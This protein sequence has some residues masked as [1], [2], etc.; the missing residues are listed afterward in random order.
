MDTQLSL[1]IAKSNAGRLSR[2]KITNAF[3]NQVYPLDELMVLALDISNKNHYKAIWIVELLAEENIFFLNPYVTDILTVSGKFKHQS[4]V[5]GCSRILYFMSSSKLL[6]L[7]EKQKNLII[8]TCLDWLINN[9]KVAC[10]ALSLKTLAYLSNE[11]NWLKEEL[12]EIIAKDYSQQ[13][14]GYQ[15]AAREVLSRIKP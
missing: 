15:A 7:S 11:F 5:R 14:P 2:Q 1:V 3:L 6:T 12:K 10:K 8:E 4:A 13:S 9:Q